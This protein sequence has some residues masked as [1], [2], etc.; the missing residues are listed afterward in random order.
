MALNGCLILH[1]YG[2]GAFVDGDPPR[3]SGLRL[4][5]ELGSAYG[6]RGDSWH[7]VDRG[8][9]LFQGLHTCL[10]DDKG[11]LAFPAPFRAA[12][13][14]AG[15]GD[16]FVLTQSFHDDCLVALSERDF[17]AQ[18]EKIRGLPPSNPAVLSFK[19]YFIAPATVMVVDKAGRVNVPKELREYAGLEREVMWAGVIERIE[20]WA[21]QRWDENNARHK[22]D[23]A[24]REAMRAF[25]ENH[26]F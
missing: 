3:G 1:A 18:C 11:R 9:S 15:L 14:K 21:K 10:M 22:N 20:L 19:R 2:G 26:G 5:L 17:E 6:S 4:T 24:E 13:E 16:R 8:G 25:L 7:F 23:A 12:L